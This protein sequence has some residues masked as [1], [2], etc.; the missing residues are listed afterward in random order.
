MVLL[1]RAPGVNKSTD[2]KR[3]RH[4][5]QTA[6][7]SKTRTHLSVWTVW[8]P[9]TLLAMVFA[10]MDSHEPAT[11][12]SVMSAARMSAQRGR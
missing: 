3:F 6:Y 5:A 9:R 10:A 2:I 8:P 12:E 4:Q 1:T 11:A 7:S